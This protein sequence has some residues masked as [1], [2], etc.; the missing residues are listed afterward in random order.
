M[1]AV[2]ID[3]TLA[4]KLP[5][6]FAVHAPD[7]SLRVI[8]KDAMHVTAEEILAVGHPAP[9]ALVANLPYNVAV[10]VLLHMLEILPSPANNLGDGPGRSCRPAGR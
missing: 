5:T 4:A 2:E 6:T 3:P 1:T 10:P 8:T 9:T 7:S